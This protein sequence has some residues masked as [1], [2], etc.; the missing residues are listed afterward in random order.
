MKKA[1][2]PEHQLPI[3]PVKAS[4]DLRVKIT[5]QYLTNGRH[6][7]PGM[8]EREV[9]KELRDVFDWEPSTRVSVARFKPEPPP[10]VMELALCESKSL[11][12]HP[13]RLYRFT[14]IKG[15]QACEKM[16]AQHEQDFGNAS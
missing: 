15:C 6:T 2:A 11:D 13:N 12:L 4:V 14:P 7:T 3:K 9:R 1:I 10:E 8:L 5:A 16:L